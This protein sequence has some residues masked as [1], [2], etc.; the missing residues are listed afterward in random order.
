M[1]VSVG[2]R[3]PATRT[4]SVSSNALDKSPQVLHSTVYLQEQQ[5]QFSVGTGHDGEHSLFG[6]AWVSLS[7]LSP[8]IG[9]RD[10]AEHQ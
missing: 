10:N 5:A 8:T 6:V 3:V 9:E 1:A 4:S 7:V 2:Q